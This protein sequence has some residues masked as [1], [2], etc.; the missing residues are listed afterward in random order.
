MRKILDIKAKALISG[1]A[2]SRW[3]EGAL[4]DTCQGLNPFIESD[5]YRGI[6]ACT[7]SPTDMTSTTVVDIPVAHTVDQ[8]GSTNVLYVL[9]ASGHLYS[10]APTNVVSDLR[11]GT[12]IN[13]PANG[14]AIM[15]PVGGSIVLLFARDSRI[16]TWDMSGTFP[17]GWNDSTYNPGTTTEHR[18]MH[19]FD[20]IV[21]F[22]N[23]N[24]VGYFYD[25]G[26]AA[27][28][29]EAQGLSLDQ[30][31]EVTAISDD[32]RYVI[33]GASKPTDASYATNTSCRVLFWNGGTDEILW[34]VTLHNESSIRSIINKGGRTYVIG[35]RGVYVVQLGVSDAQTIYTFDSDEAIPYDGLSYGNPNAAAPFYD[36]IIFGALGTA[37]TKGEPTMDTGVFQPLQGIT[38]DISLYITDFKTGY[39][40]VGT[41]SS[42]LYR[43]NLASAGPT[44]N[45]WVTR[46]I[47]LGTPHYINKLRMYF[48]NGIGGSD[49][50]SVIA[51]AED[52][53]ETT[54]TITVN[55]TNYGDSKYADI[56]FTQPIRTSKLRLSFA[57]SAGLPS[58]S[59]IEVWGD[60]ST[61]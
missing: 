7:A 13:A 3:V 29:M 17:T 9:G 18:P 54:D 15:Q 60:K 52:G 28:A 2:R 41:R 44:S 20:R 27:I 55:Q 57:P 59:D 42:K 47:D 30:R 14:M 19:T 46:A 21:Y 22:G 33:V 34:Q 5:T 6:V 25:D 26:A 16:G 35:S 56:Y 8:R 50:L 4:W 49:V 12:P 45:T 36:G 10:I 39:I 32:G 48:P 38:G 37:I 11:S 40:Y 51:I 43:V 53:D 31:E 24:Y 58:F 23:K 61:L 1:K